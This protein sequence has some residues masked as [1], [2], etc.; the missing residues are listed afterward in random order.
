MYGYAFIQWKIALARMQDANMQEMTQQ[1][2]LRR[3]LFAG[4]LRLDRECA[5]LRPLD[6]GFGRP[7]RPRD[8]GQ[9][10]HV[11]RRTRRRRLDGK[12][13]L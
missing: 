10:G 11:A 8:R 6:F 1:G 5:D 13:E 3:F 2:Q 9:L 12:V 7:D 4:R